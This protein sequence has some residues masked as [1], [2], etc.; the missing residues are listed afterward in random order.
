[1]SFDIGILILRVVLGLA[2]M[3]HGS[4]K[5]FGW[6]EG[7]GWQGN[8]GMITRMGLRPAWFWALVSGMSE[9]GGGLLLAL[10]LLSPIG[11]LGI[12]AAML[13]AIVKVHWKNGFWS[14]K[15]GFEYPLINLTAALALALTGPGTLSLDHALGINFPEPAVLLIGL[16]VVLLG[17]FGQDLT[18]RTVPSDSQSAG[19]G[20]S[21]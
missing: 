12:I 17:F 6:F 11:S 4:Q 1:M 5:L 16:A 3:G 7:S 10:G 18:R 20:S 19:Q 13:T 9:F 8:L 2:F 15:H 14:T 21:S